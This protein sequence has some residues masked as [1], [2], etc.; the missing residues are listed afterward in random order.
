VRTAAATVRQALTPYNA[1]AGR[2]YRSA[3]FRKETEKRPKGGWG[4]TLGDRSL[5]LGAW[6]AGPGG[7]MCAGPQPQ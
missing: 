5:V 2:C 1:P 4:R 6:R 3:S 7:S